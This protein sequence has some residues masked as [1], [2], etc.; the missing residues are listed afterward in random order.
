LVARK[1]Q[2]LSITLE[3]RAGLCEEGMETDFMDNVAEDVKR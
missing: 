3:S 1:E 2:E